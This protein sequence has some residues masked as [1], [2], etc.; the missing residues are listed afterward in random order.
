MTNQ[1]IIDYY[2][3]LLI[4]QYVGKPKA[5]ATIQASAKPFVMD[6]LPVAVQGAFDI[7]TAVGVQ[8]DLLGKYIG[9]TRYGYTFTGPVTLSD[10]EYRVLLKVAIIKNSAGSSLSVIQDLLHLF[11]NMTLLVF[12]YQNMHMDYFFDSTIG[13]R[14]LAELFVQEGVLPK[15]MGVQLGS[16]IYSANVARFFGFRTYPLPGYNVTPFNS[17]SPYVTN[18]PWLSYTDA[19]A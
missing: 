14:P 11:F 15:P 3:N 12:D 5:Y 13:S 10:A 18:S 8:L 7:D 9:V 1:E 17:Y 4:L 16:L 6:Q 19:I 2:A